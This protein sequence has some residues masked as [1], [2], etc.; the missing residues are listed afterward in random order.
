MNI[1]QLSR[2][3]FTKKIRPVQNSTDGIL[4]TR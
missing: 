4:Y 3:G 2:A 1:L